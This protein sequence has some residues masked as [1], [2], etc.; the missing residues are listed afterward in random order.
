MESPTHG[1][2]A[3]EV[4]DYQHQGGVIN[5]RRR[6]NAYDTF[7]S[8]G[9]CRKDTGVALDI[10]C[11]TT[12]IEPP[13]TLTP[14]K[15]AESPEGEET[16]LFLESCSCPPI[17][18]SH[19]QAKKRQVLLENACHLPCCHISEA[20]ISQSPPALPHHHHQN[21]C[22]DLHEMMLAR[23]RGGGEEAGR[24]ANG[25]IQGLTTCPS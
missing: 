25:Q 2:H 21:P 18:P 22:P 10:E 23:R 19:T 8:S 9:G 20:R 24:A 3:T 4:P 14:L 15:S 13:A 16:R 11:F 7:C 17:R 5:A 1:Q 12:R 6:R